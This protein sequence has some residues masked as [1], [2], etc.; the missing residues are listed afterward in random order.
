MRTL[1]K[2]IVFAALIALLGFAVTTPKNAYA[3]ACSDAGGVCRALEGKCL[4][5]ENTSSLGC[6]QL[7][8]TCCVT[9]STGTPRCDCS[10]DADCTGGQT[11]DEGASASCRRVTSTDPTGLC[12]S[13]GSG[14]GGGIESGDALDCVDI[15]LGTCI[16]TTPEALAEVILGIG[17]GVG[18]LLAILFLIVGGFGIATSGG[19]P[20][21]LEKSKGQ[22]TAAISGLLFILLSVLILNILGVK[23]LGIN[24]F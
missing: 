16:P 11:C 6:L 20:E 14:D 21:N 3:S 13:T 2:T 9:P 19:N 8:E 7:D 5:G 10:N 15:G 23:I 4:S 24:I 18:T 22:I 1:L 17:I 12:K